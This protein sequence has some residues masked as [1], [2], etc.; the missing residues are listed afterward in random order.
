MALCFIALGSN[1]GDGR[2]NLQEA[3]QT[4][5]KTAGV[6]LVALSSPYRSE[7]LGIESEFSFVNAVG[8]L[9][10]TLAPKD[11]LELLLGIELVMGRDR[12]KGSDRIIDLDILYIDD[13]VLALPELTVP[14]PEISQRLFV[15]EPLA[16]LAP[17]HIHPVN[18][19]TT[20]TM[21]RSLEAAEPQYI[22]KISWSR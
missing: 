2:R 6:N 18:S 3:W 22:K 7:P 1:L 4:I 5:G 10:T 13:L 20:R 9:F 14:H 8:A 15:L 12:S 16:D 21:I 17:D 19:F 11:L